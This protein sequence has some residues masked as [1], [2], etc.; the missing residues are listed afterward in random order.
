MF[1][2]TTPC[3]FP[4]RLPSSVSPVHHTCDIRCLVLVPI[5][6]EG[7]IKQRGNG[8]VEMNWYLKSYFVAESCQLVYLY[9][10]RVPVHFP[11]AGGA[12]R[13]RR[14][15]MLRQTSP[16]LD[17]IRRNAGET[18]DA[19]TGCGSSKDRLTSA[20]ALHR[21]QWLSFLIVL[22]SYTTKR[23]MQNACQNYRKVKSR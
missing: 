9:L 19:G 6:R 18:T 10:I 17:G 20:W 12:Y 1:S 21:G 7:K 22:F 3:R 11:N 14:A 16:T 15:W 5:E 4:D 8:T 13:Q 23:W 2:K